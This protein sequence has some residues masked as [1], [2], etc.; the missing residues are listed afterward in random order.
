MK[1]SLLKQLRAA[2]GQLDF[3]E[4]VRLLEHALGGVDVGAVDRTA[5]SDR[6]RFRHSPGLAFPA[7]D[8]ASLRI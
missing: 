2:P 3:F 4:L 5:F 7:T 1:A 8:V 6:I